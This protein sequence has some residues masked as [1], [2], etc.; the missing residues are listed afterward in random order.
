MRGGS[1]GSDIDDEKPVT[2]VSFIGGLLLLFLLLNAIKAFGRMSPQ[3]VARWA[4]RGGWFL[5]V[6]SL[7]YLALAGRGGLLRVLGLGLNNPFTQR[8]PDPLSDDFISAGRGQGKQRSSVARTAWVEMHLEHDTGAM[9]GY[10]LA[11]PYSG[12]DLSQMSRDE[13]L[14]FYRVCSSQDPEGARLLETYFDRRFTAWREADEG[15]SKAGRGGGRS[16]DS[17]GAM[18]R[19]EAYEVLGL[20]KGAGADEIVRAHRSLMKKLHPDHGGSTALAARVNQA[21]DVLLDRHV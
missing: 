18:T 21:K 14:Q 1:R 17:G 9:R 7:A 15:Q 12:R 2:M 8:R 6:G 5:V 16:G 20:A 19:D 11:G 13:C 3:F 10:V 4:R